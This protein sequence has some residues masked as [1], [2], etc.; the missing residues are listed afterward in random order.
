MNGQ[1]VQTA[2]SAQIVLPDLLAHLWLN[3][4]TSGTTTVSSVRSPQRC[5][6]AHSSNPEISNT[7]IKKPTYN[8]QDWSKVSR[9]YYLFCIYFILHFFVY[10]CFAEIYYVLASESYFCLCGNQINWNNQ[11][12]NILRANKETVSVYKQWSKYN[13]ITIICKTVA[14]VR[15]A[16]SIVF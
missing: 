5:A 13:Y 15:N 12:N 11:L 9:Q 10:V 16:Y 6:T 14:K 1:E 2:Q 7:A 8:A 3:N 4:T